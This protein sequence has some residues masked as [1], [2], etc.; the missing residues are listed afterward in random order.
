MAYC[1]PPDGALA[2]FGKRDFKDFV[3][4]FRDLEQTP[5]E[6]MAARFWASEYYVPSA[7]VAPSVRAAPAALPSLRQQPVLSQLSTLTRRYLKVILA[8]KSYLRLIALFPIGLG[9]IPRVIPA[10]DGLDA[11]A[12]R[13]NGDATKVL[14][15]LVLCACFMGMANSVR[16]IVKE[17]DIYRRERTIGL[18]RSAY[19]GS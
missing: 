18:S 3:D 12:D 10:D 14:V 8:D 19:L 11:I 1:G 7:M 2:Y 17:R 13:P 16:E 15:V 5:G 6:E 4:V 9:I